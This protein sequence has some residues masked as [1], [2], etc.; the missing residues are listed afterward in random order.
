M[1]INFHLSPKDEC[2][3][4]DYIFERSGYFVAYSG[5][6]KSHYETFFKKLPESGES[7]NK[8][9]NLLLFRMDYAPIQPLRTEGVIS[10]IKNLR[11]H[12]LSR[13]V[14][15]SEL[16]DKSGFRKEFIQ[17]K[18][19][20]VRDDTLHWGRLWM[21]GFELEPTKFYRN[22]CAHIRK[23]CSKSESW[24]WVG[25]DVPNYLKTNALRLGQ[26]F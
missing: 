24:D 4:L 10:R 7:S 26:H 9:A 17:Y 6:H 8:Y 23:V 16:L 20:I 22:L 11:K 19:C 2:H 15:S 14:P 1:Q 12:P 13:Q 5:T 3:L 18:R 21:N 25:N